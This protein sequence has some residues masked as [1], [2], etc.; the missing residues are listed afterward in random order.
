MKPYIKVQVAR[1]MSLDIKASWVHTI[2]DDAEDV[3]M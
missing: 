3:Y 1:M 2:A